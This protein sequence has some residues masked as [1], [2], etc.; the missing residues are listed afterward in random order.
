MVIFVSYAFEDRAHFENITDALED[1]GLEYWKTGDTRAGEQLSKQLQDAI[2]HSALCIFIA[3]RNSVASSWCNAELGAFWGAKKRVLIFIADDTLQEADLPKQFQGH[4]LQRR[5]KGLVKDCKQYLEELSSSGDAVGDP[6]EGVF[7]HKVTREDLTM[8][9]EDAI[10]RSSSNSLAVSAFLELETRQVPAGN[11]TISE[12]N[13]RS[14]QRTLH[15]FMGLSRSSVDETAPQR[16]PH[17]IAVQTTTGNWR[18]YAKTATWQ[19]YNYVH[20]PCI[21][22]KFDEKF[23]VEAIALFRW[24][25]ELDKG[26]E[27]VGGLIAAVGKHEFGELHQT[28]EVTSSSGT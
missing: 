17:A 9:I 18:G 10:F 5:I 3:T 26:G 15:S 14:L 12:D 24:Y 11:E 20:T 23:H 6:S 25:V 28:P 27:T 8:L 19:S 2:S 21:F 4:F 7:L 16:W 22:F 13:T 1:A